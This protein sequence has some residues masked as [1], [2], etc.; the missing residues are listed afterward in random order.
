[1][2]FVFKRSLEAG[3]NLSCRTLVGILAL[4]PA[5]AG[6]YASEW[7]LKPALAGLFLSKGEARLKPAG[8]LCYMES[9]S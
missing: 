5:S 6:G 2:A 9:T 7:L 4:P 8:G 3:E 1:M